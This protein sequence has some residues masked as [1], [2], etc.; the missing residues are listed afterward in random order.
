MISTFVTQRSCTAISIMHD[1]SEQMVEYNASGRHGYRPQ[2]CAI[3]TYQEVLQGWRTSLQNWRHLSVLTFP[4]CTEV[5]LEDFLCGG[6]Y[7]ICTQ[8]TG[9]VHAISTQCN[10]IPQQAAF[11]GSAAAPTTCPRGLFLKL[12]FFV[13]GRARIRGSASL[14]RVQ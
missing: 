4:Y 12:D 9:R 3:D 5:V 14:W 1:T 10:V 8:C 2:G 11:G 6:F 13:S 7:Q